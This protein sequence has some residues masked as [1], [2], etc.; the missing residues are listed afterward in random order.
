MGGGVYWYLVVQQLGSYRPLESVHLESM[1]LIYKLVSFPGKMLELE[2]TLEISESNI[3][4][5]KWEKQDLGKG[6]SL[7]EA[8]RPVPGSGSPLASCVPS[9]GVLTTA[10]R[11]EFHRD[12]LFL[13]LLSAYLSGCPSFYIPSLGGNT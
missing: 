8:L 1:W 10:S 7:V 9:Q 4:F 13:F 12:P 6:G 11:A 5:H 3:L 2:E